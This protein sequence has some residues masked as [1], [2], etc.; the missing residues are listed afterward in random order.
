MNETKLPTGT[1]NKFIEEKTLMEPPWIAFPSYGRYS[2]GWRMG[3]GESY[4]MAFFKWRSQL[5]DEDKRVYESL[6]PPP[7]TMYDYWTPGD[8]EDLS[9]AAEFAR[10]NLFT[11]R[12]ELSGS[13]KYSKKWLEEKVKSNDDLKFKFY[14][15]SFK[16]KHK[17]YELLSTWCPVKFPA[18]CAY[19]EETMHS[20]EE[21]LLYCKAL[22]SRR[23][24]L[25][26]AVS[27]NMGYRD[28]LL[29]IKPKVDEFQSKTWDKMYPG[30]LALA[31]YFKFAYDDF[32]REVLLSTGDD[33]LVCL[34]KDLKLGCKIQVD[35][36]NGKAIL[37]G[38]NLLGFA[39]MNA[40]DEIRKIYG[41]IELCANSK[42]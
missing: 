35:K 34:D 7:I 3:A 26:K 27:F 10:S 4:L 18:S 16:P 2:L 21:Y 42:W 5:S 17:Q 32:L 8:G 38:E 29:K 39:I 33:I 24:G 25:I 12:W 22:I 31:N 15:N 40:R 20:V 41:N 13:T 36:E 23:K 14:Q 19:E 1:I 9:S 30:M 37:I 6:F 11:Y 28:D